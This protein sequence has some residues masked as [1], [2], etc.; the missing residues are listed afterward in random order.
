M[1]A[2]PRLTIAQVVEQFE[3]SR[4]TVRRGIESGKFPGASKDEQGRWLVPVDALVAAGIKARKTWLSEV[5]TGV[6]TE[7]A[8]ELAHPAHMTADP[9]QN[10]VAT[11]LAHLR[12]ELAHERAQREA[13][14][15]IAQ[16]RLDHI[17]SLN[18]AL[19]AI[20]AARPEPQ[21]RS[22]WSRAR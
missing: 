3:M 2:R 10:Q 13:A 9:I 14:E 1:S 18:T 20:E 5:A 21:R 4:A 12:N 15:R 6:A 7:L 8:H 19:R 22:W 17:A 16:E 11:E